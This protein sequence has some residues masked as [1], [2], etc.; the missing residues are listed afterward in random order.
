MDL[1]G[2]S[3]D[4]GVAVNTVKAWL[5]VLEATDQVIML[6][7]YH[8]NAGKRLVK[9]PKVYFMDVGTL[10]YLC[11]LRDPLHAMAGPMGGGIFETAVIG[12]VYRTLVHRGQEPRLFFWRTAAGA[13]VDLI[14]EREDG[15]VPIEI[16]LGSTPNPGMA[17]GIQSFRR[18]FGERAQTGL[19]VHTGGEPLPLGPGVLA[20]PFA[21][22]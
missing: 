22:L 14:V 19:V 2:L 9:T 12:E 1:S 13:E 16:K 18:D 8:S 5:S 15:L 20:W 3:R 7:P 17:K 10:C 21:R 6:R 11:G 4:L